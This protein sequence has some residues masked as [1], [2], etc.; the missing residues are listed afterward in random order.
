[1]HR[2][3]S[4]SHGATLSIHLCTSIQP[5]TASEIA[6]KKKFPSVFVISD[7]WINMKKSSKFINSIHFLVLKTMKLEL[8]MTDSQSFYATQMHRVAPSTS[9]WRRRMYCNY[10]DSSWIPLKGAGC[11]GCFEHLE[12]V[13]QTTSNNQIT[14]VSKCQTTI[15]IK[16][17]K[18]LDFHGW[19]RQKRHKNITELPRVPAIISKG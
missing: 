2:C 10:P 16:S 17:I 11:W 3:R 1:M 7:W 4:T 5:N 8:T 14:T 13:I 18:M 9:L 12:H 19:S 15:D 6:L